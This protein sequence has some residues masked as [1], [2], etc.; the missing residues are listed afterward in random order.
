MNVWR[1]YISLI[2]GTVLI[3][4]CI[5]WAQD[6]ELKFPYQAF[7]IVDKAP[8]YSG[9]GSVHY[10]TDELKVDAIVEVHRHDPE[11]WCAI[12]PPVESFSLIPA[13]AIRKLS[14]NVGVVTEQG[15]P[16]WV[17]TQLGAVEQPLW[18]VK[19]RED[20][21]VKILGE[22]SWPNPEGYSTTWFQVAPP[23]GEFRWIRKSDLRL[24]QQSNELPQIADSNLPG[25]ANRIQTGIS[26]QSSIGAVVKSSFQETDPTFDD[27]L[28]PPSQRIGTANRGWR[29]AST[30][31]RIADNRAA[32]QAVEPFKIP[33]I[34]A[35]SIADAAN[36]DPKL[37]KKTPAISLPAKNESNLT[38]DL[39]PVKGPISERVRL[40]DSSLTTEMLKSPDQWKLE[41][42]LRQTTAI[43]TTTNDSTERQHADRLV[44]KIRNCVEIQ[45]R[46]ESAYV[47]SDDKLSLG[48]TVGT[49]VDQD[50]QLSTTYDAHG[51]LNQLVRGKGSL[52]P[53]YVLENDQGKIVSHVA[54]APG[55]N[56]N[57]Y[58]KS[59]VGIVGR[60]G[61]NREL[62][63]KHVTAERI[64][65]LDSIRR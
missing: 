47:K 17:G 41:T 65:V 3:S 54:A 63:M 58:I 1:T 42:L 51:W 29:K 61:F 60:R 64:M 34:D 26:E 50:V 22:V 36:V 59:K 20:E 37:S 21:Q 5:L 33:A 39:T 27:S 38:L 16:A 35:P 4:P 45:N 57:R 52:Q 56:L 25:S 62:K 31:I 53:T 23:S 14:D 28:D 44:T 24:P 49:G 55:L 12:R 15:I 43:S 40:L 32:S 13:T 9:P 19:L 30:P 2:V 48:G 11:G 8:V 6:D 10:S 46:F 18:Q 7:V